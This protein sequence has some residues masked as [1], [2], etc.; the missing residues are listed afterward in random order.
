[1]LE[2]KTPPAKNRRATI[3]RQ[4]QKTRVVL[5]TTRVGLVPAVG[6]CVANILC[7]RQ[8]CC[9][10]V[11]SNLAMLEYVVLVCHWCDGTALKGR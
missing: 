9:W 2:K 11:A 10:L 4:K 3:L 8:T 5:R 7:G 1:M 6:L